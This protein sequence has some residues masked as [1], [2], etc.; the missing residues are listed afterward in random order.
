MNGAIT[1]THAR[2]RLDGRGGLDAEGALVALRLEHKLRAES[3]H[4]QPT[5]TAHAALL[6]RELKQDARAG[7]AIDR[8]AE[9]GSGKQQHSNC[10]ARRWGAR[11][12]APCGLEQPLAVR[13]DDNAPGAAPQHFRAPVGS[14][15]RRREVAQGE[16]S[17]HGKLQARDM[18]ETD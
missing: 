9:K 11:A 18:I 6:L 17:A 16:Q 10:R 3:Q 14:P 5:V 12:R 13:C 2:A 1:G 8:L 15:R 7:R 4:E